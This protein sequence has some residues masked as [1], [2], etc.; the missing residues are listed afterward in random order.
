MRDEEEKNLQRAR[1]VPPSK[2]TRTTPMV[3]WRRSV[4][5]SSSNPIP[6]LFLLF[7]FWGGGIVAPNLN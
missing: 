2:S 7:F 1:E 4:V 6:Q 3:N 5:P